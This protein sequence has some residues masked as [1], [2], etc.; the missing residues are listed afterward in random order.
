[1]KRF[2]GYI[3]KKLLKRFAC[4][5]C[6]Y[7]LLLFE[8]NVIEDKYIKLLTRGGLLITN[9]NVGFY[10]SK[11]FAILDVIFDVLFKHTQMILE[12]VLNISWISIS[13]PIDICCP[14]HNSSSRRWFCR[15]VSNHGL[16]NNTV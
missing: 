15:I 6:K 3:I 14:T 11:C 2:T 7:L 13:P 4:N 16:L 5:D 1:M 12:T 8:E 10:S 9:S